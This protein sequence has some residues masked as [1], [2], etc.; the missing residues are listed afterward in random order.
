MSMKQEFREVVALSANSTDMFGPAD[1]GHHMEKALRRTFENIVLSLRHGEMG[2][3]PPPNDHV[4][5]IGGWEQGNGLSVP[6]SRYHTTIK[7]DYGEHR[8]PEWDNCSEYEVH[9]FVDQP[10]LKQYGV[11]T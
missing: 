6:R 8:E 4:Y 10:A 5:C 11:R 9:A 3:Y 7:L 2:Y 1:V